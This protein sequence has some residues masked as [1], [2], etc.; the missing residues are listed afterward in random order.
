VTRTLLRRGLGA[1]LIGGIVVVYLGCVGMIELF[2]IRNLISNVVTLGKVMLCLPAF[3]AGY[4]AVRPRVR[5]GQVEQ[6]PAATTLGTGA[7]AGAVSGVLV[8][9][10]LILV[11]ALG[12]DSVRGIFISVSPGLLTVLQFGQDVPVAAAILIL[13]GAALAVLGAGLRLLPRA[14]RR[15]LFAGLFTTFLFALLQRIIPPALAQLKVNYTWLYSTT[16]FGLTILGAILVFVVATGLGYWWQRDRTAARERIAG[17][18]RTGFR[19]VQAVVLLVILG[20]LAVLPLLVG[21]QLSQVLGTVAIFLL[22]GLG[23]NVVVGL[24]GLLDLG[25]VAFFAVGAYT[26]AIL[27]GGKLV[28]SLGPP[29]APALHADF[30]FYAAIPL[31]VLFAAFIGLLIGAPVLRLRGDYL[32]I[33]TLGFGEIARIL[34]QSDWW[35]PI[36]GGAQGMTNITDAGLFGVRFDN[37]KNFYYLA[38][39][40]CLIAVFVSLR[41][42]SSRIGRAWSAMREDEQVAEAMGIST[43]KY[44]L[45]AFAIGAGIGCLGGALFAVQVRSLTPASFTILISITVLAVIILG[46]MGSTPGV[47]VGALL[48]IGIPNLLSEF[49]QFRLLLYGAVLIAIMVLRPQGVIPNVRRS[50]EL[51]VEEVDQDAWLRRTGDASVDATVAVGAPAGGTEEPAT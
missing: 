41:L 13:G 33:V 1:G 12:P 49:E 6:M 25:Y 4:I 50:R 30:S 3:V 46:G 18:S 7:V 51:H 27:S 16:F 42:A 47:V 24:A 37:P 44:K 10:F 38:L 36:V 39:A 34:V 48:L 22:M 17:L 14:V 20:I 23:L 2:E 8:V 21:I 9:L 32:A 5:R 15:A 28:Q 31:V 26:M 43:V 19:G 35:K 11:H 40:F 45:L 29:T